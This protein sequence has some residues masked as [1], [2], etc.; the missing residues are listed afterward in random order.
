MALSYLWFRLVQSYQ[1]INTAKFSVI[2]IIESR[3]PIRPFVAEW[4][5][6]GMIKNPKVYRP[7]TIIELGIPWIFF[8]LNSFVLL[9][10]IPWGAFNA[11]F[12][13]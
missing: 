8:S 4:E 2:H 5:A 7:I 3:L 6:L 1:G 9:R 10:S 11:W 12:S 13:R